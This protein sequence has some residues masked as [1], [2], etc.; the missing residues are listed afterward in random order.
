MRKGVKIRTRLSSML[1]PTSLA[2]EHIQQFQSFSNWGTF[3]WRHR[4]VASLRH[5]SGSAFWNRGVDDCGGSAWSGNGIGEYADRARNGLHQNNHHSRWSLNRY[6]WLPQLVRCGLCRP[7]RMGIV[8][9]R[10]SGWLRTSSTST[11]CFAGLPSGDARI[12][13]LALRS[14]LVGRPI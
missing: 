2:E 1:G 12:I 6:S 5:G 13:V 3:L 8:K 10:E 14:P 7:P 9:V 11:A 4:Y